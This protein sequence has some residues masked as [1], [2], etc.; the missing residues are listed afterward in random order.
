MFCF[1]ML[2]CKY[3]S[4]GIKAKE[5]RWNSPERAPF[6]SH[7]MPG[8]HLQSLAH[9]GVS[10]GKPRRFHAG[11]MD[12]QPGERPNTHKNTQRIPLSFQRRKSPES[13]K[14]PTQ[15]QNWL[16]M[17]CTANYLSKQDHRSWHSLCQE[18]AASGGSKGC[19]AGMPAKPLH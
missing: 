2:S 4:L 16:C 7:T 10:A 11:R 14:P 5:R 1:S 3:I 18:T 17:V 15:T 19:G 6:R 8:S 12:L 13:K 9:H